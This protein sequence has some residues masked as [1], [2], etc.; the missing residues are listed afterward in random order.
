M[1]KLTDFINESINEDNQVIT[2][3]FQNVKVIY[4][5][6]IDFFIKAPIKYSESDIQIYLE[7]IC[8]N[9]LP[10]AQ[11]NASRFFGM[12]SNNISNRYFEYSSITTSQA[13]NPTINIDWDNHYDQ[14]V[15]GEDLAIFEIKNIKYI[16]EFDKFILK[17]VTEDSYSDVLN[18]IF[19]QTISSA[20]HKYPIEISLNT[21]NIIVEE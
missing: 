8:L 5:G 13:E 6:P 4:D 3:E 1:K 9:K 19:T 17:D 18:N 20:S 14:S 2:K 21:A 7:D 16:I 12:N 11:N 15:K 10:G